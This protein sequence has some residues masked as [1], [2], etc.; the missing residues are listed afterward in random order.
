MTLS[1][2]KLLAYGWGMGLVLLSAWPAF[3]TPRVDSYPLSTYP[4]FSERRG[5]PW[6]H[7]IVAVDRAGVSVPLPPSLIANAETLQAAAAV[8]RAVEGGKG[9][10]RALCTEVITR[11]ESD[12][13]F[14]HV[15]ELRIQAVQYDPLEYFQAL[16]A[17]LT[18]RTL[19]SCRVP[20]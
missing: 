16:R 11:I 9:A 7:R 18:T 14:Q 19:H 2:Q 5:Q 20:R 8:R 3:R 17:P 13:E 6:L 1:A 12:P 10:M 4:M 15:R